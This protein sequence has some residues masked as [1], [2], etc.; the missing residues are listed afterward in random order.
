[1]TSFPLVPMIVAVL[2]RHLGRVAAAGAPGA[3]R[4]SVVTKIPAKTIGV[5][6]PASKRDLLGLWQNHLTCLASCQL[7][8]AEGPK[9]FPDP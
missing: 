9:A 2:L 5:R 4:K 8:L 1:M 3:S 6:R 7:R